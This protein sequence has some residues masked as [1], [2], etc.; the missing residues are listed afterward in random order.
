MGLKKIINKAQKNVF[1]MKKTRRVKSPPA[2]LLL[3]PLGL[4]E[5]LWPFFF[6]LIQTKLVAPSQ[7]KIA[8]P[9]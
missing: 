2:S 1:K 5:D 6:D 9:I 8:L 3:L 4:F 7:K